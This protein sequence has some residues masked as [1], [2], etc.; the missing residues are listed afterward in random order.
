MFIGGYIRKKKAVDVFLADIDKLYD[1]LRLLLIM[2]ADILPFIELNCYDMDSG[3]ELASEKVALIT[4]IFAVLGHNILQFPHM[5]KLDLYACLL[6]VIGKILY[7]EYANILAP[8]FFPLLKSI[9]RGLD[10]EEPD[11]SLVDRF[12]NSVKNIIKDKLSNDNFIAFY[13]TLL[14]NKYSN[15]SEDDMNYFGERILETIKETDKSNLAFTGIEKLIKSAVRTKNTLYFLEY[16][17][18]SIFSNFNNQ[19]AKMIN[20][21]IALLSTLVSSYKEEESDKAVASLTLL[22]IY[23]CKVSRE[24]VKSDTMT[25]VL[26]LIQ[27]NAHLFKRSTLENLTKSQRN[28]IENILKAELKLSRSLHDKKNITLKS[29]E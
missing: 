27:N 10:K 23:L 13:L 22:L 18:R 29:F 7:S 9:I 3:I 17:F 5:F 28:T 21:Y 16:L 12:Y 6:F 2:I 11:F 24:Q 26:L 15:F 8:A 4:Q 25:E 1:L 20:T 19:E 14:G